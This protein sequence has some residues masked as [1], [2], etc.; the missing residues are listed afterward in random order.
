MKVWLI[1]EGEPIT[2]LDAKTRP[3]RLGLLAQA[4]ISQGH[5]VLWWAS[6][7]DHMTKKQRFNS[8]QT[9]EVQPGFQIRLL[10]GPGYAKSTSLKRLFHHRATAEAFWQEALKTPVKPE[11]IFCCLPTLQLAAKAISYGQRF[12]IPVIIDIRD[13]WPDHFYTLL[14]P[15]LRKLGPNLFWLDLRRARQICHNA[16]AITAISKTYLAWALNHAGRPQGVLDQVFPIGYP[17][18]SVQRYEPASIEAKMAQLRESHNLSPETVVITFI[19]TFISSFDLETVIQ[20]AKIL[21]Q[22]KQCPTK[23]ILAGDG[24][25]NQHLREL[26]KGLPNIVFTGFLDGTTLWALMQI[27]DVGLAPYKAEALMSLPNKPFEYMAAGLPILSSLSGELENLISAEQI[28]RQYQS[29]DV[30]SLVEKLRWF[31]DN[32]ATRKAMANRSQKL[33]EKQ[34]K[35]DVIYPQLVTHLENIVKDWKEKAKN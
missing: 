34:F 15:S 23:I 4:L 29:G 26:A 27:S 22:D 35:S 16:T 11:L 6:T 19:G 3:F 28:G 13:L 12:A 5:D 18:E 2:A 25:Q 10:Y 8:T 7:F 17:T 20:A 31:A 1:K 24:D 14:P 30:A 32:P 33:F 21:A 9:I